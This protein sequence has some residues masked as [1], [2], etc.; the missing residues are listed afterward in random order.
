MTDP[1]LRQRLGARSDLADLLPYRAPQLDAAV[2]LNVNES[3]Y[4]P[5]ETFMRALAD[6][7]TALPLHRYPPRDFP[8][9]R[10]RLAVYLGTLSDRVWVANGS[11]E[12]ILQLVLAFGGA[13][14]KALTFEPTYGMHSHI[15]RVSGTRPLRGRRNPDY[16]LHLEATVQA[17]RIQE[18]DI[19]FLCSPNN[20]TGNVDREEDLGAI[21]HAAPGLV[22]LD[23]AYAE[24]SGGSMMRLVEDHE[25]L[26]IVRSFSKAWRMAGAR[27]GY[28]IAHPWVIEQV[29]KVRL[30]YHL[31]M[32]TQAAALTA[33]D[34]AAEL[35]STIVTLRHERER[36]WRELSTTRGIVAFPSQANFVL[37]RCEAKPADDVWQQLLDRGVLVRNFT[38]VVGCEGCLRVSVGT[39]EQ[40][41]R[42]LDA[43]FEVLSR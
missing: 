17:I 3:P 31:S 20:P 41:E 35:A 23:E 15:T 40:N 28:L 16:S 25:Q 33:L 2:R 37:F 14:R 42:F 43:L 18:P 38:D 21:C 27:I 10:D 36:L 32:L 4:P 22:I 34:H 39:S 12:I 24:F 19:V 5:P 30:P 26:V 9:L 8:E 6:R 11:N 7:I 1:E 29:F 13:E